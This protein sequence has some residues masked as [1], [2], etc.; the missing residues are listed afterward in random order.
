M[1]NK[2]KMIIAVAVVLL[3]AGNIYLL[4]QNNA[5]RQALRA[6]QEQPSA[7][8]VN[9]KVLNFAKLFVQKVLKAEG[10][11]DFETRLELENAVRGIGDSDILAQWQRFVES[12]TEQEAQAEVKNLLELL[13]NKIRVS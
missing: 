7:T 4:Q 1:G 6:S 13:V 3:L 2:N 11:I 5:A 8:E 12:K 10:E 9:E